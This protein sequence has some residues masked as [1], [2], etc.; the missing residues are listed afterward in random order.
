M[1][2]EI[3]S[4]HRWPVHGFAMQGCHQGSELSIRPRFRQ[5]IEQVEFPKCRLRVAQQHLKQ[6][7]PC[8]QHPIGRW[9]QSS[10]FTELSLL[11][12]V[13]LLRS[14]T[15]F[16]GYSPPYNSVGPDKSHGISDRLFTRGLPVSGSGWT[17]TNE[18][19]VGSSGQ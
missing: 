11:D 8:E 6:M 5:R 9:N 1:Q 13:A 12:L 10:H 7:L 2:N 14:N 16:W 19:A 17:R 15:E 18:R 3:Q 4:T